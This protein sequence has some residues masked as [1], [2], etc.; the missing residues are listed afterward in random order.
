[1]VED[2]MTGTSK[3][4]KKKNKNIITIGLAYS[5]QKIKKIKINNNDMKLIFI[6]KDKKN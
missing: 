3:E 1:M 5:F 6:L 4:L 2:F